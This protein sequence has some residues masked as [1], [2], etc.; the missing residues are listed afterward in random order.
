MT[1]KKKP[2]VKVKKPDDEAAALEQKRLDDEAAAL[3]P[4]E[5]PD[6]VDVIHKTSEKEFTVSRAY[7]LANKGSLRL[8]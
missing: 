4:E 7:Y 6:A 1:T 8:A 3:E 5:L 2:P